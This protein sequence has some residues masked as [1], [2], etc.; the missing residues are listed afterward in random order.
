M[1]TKAEVTEYMKSEWRLF[2]KTGSDIHM[3]K[4]QTACWVLQLSDKEIE[5]IFLELQ[6]EG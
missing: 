2:H 4:A 3:A 1:K 6:A 5:K